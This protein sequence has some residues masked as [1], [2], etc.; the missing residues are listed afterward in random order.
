MNLPKFLLKDTS[1][2][3]SI[4]IRLLFIGLVI[5][6][7]GG[8]P[9]GVLNLKAMQMAGNHNMKAAWLF[10]G[11]VM[12]AEALA[13]LVAIYLVEK[14]KINNKSVGLL[15]YA[16]SILF[17]AIAAVSF[18]ALLNEGTHSQVMQASDTVAFPFFTGFG[19]SIINPLHI[20]FWV[21]WTAFVKSKGF[22]EPSSK[23]TYPYLT[24][25]IIGS[26]LSF[27]PYTLLGSA[28]ILYLPDFAWFTNLALVI[29]FSIVSF[30]LFIKGTTHNRKQQ[31]KAI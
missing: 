2:P 4:L 12:V 14:I 31:L 19:I 26:F 15:Y 10:I 9:M 23:A 7:L 25:I 21:G 5:S 22:L 17:L 11:G 8:L 6:F 27:I 3:K 16:A 24:G 1:S 20:P 28:L 18:N 30:S 13:V 29:A